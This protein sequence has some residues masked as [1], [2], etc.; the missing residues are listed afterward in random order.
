MDS[1]DAITKAVTRRFK[2]ERKEHDLP[3]GFTWD[4]QKKKYCQGDLRALLR[5]H[6][7]S[8]WEVY[9]RIS[10]PSSPSQKRPR[11]NLPEHPDRNKFGYVFCHRGL[12]DRARG[13]P[14]NSLMAVD[15]GMRNGLFFHELD[16][17]LS[18]RPESTTFGGSIFITHD[19]IASRVS[20]KPRR[21]N[22]Y[23]LSEIKQTP[24]VQRNFNED[25]GTYASS[26][27]NTTQKVPFLG[28]LDPIWFDEVEKAVSDGSDTYIQLDLRGKDFADAL[29]QF[30]GIGQTGPPS[31]NL[32]LKGYNTHFST[33]EKLKAATLNSKLYKNSYTFSRFPSYDSPLRFPFLAI[34]VFYPDPIIDLALKDKHIHLKKVGRYT[35]S[36]E[37]ICDV[38]RTQLLSFHSANEYC[39]IFEIV[40]TGLGLGYN[41]QNGTARNPLDGTL[42][43]DPDVIFQSRV[44]RAM[45]DV[46]LKL[47]ETHP[48][49][50]F[51]SCTRL[52]DVRTSRGVEMTWN[53][54]TG[55]MM[56][57]PDGE[58]G[59]AKRLRAIHGG[60]YPQSDIV[61]ADDPYAEIAARTWIDEHAR[62]DRSK[63]LHMTYNDWI[64]QGEEKAVGLAAAIEKLQGPFLPNQYDEPPDAGLDIVV[65]EGA[66]GGSGHQMQRPQG[67]GAK[68]RNDVENGRNEYRGCC[69]L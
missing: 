65:D 69:V 47:K 5:T 32:I 2:N 14:E 28:D 55:K 56:I 58:R 49:V 35:L 36:Y 61:V 67:H 38:F 50:M 63:L 18:M 8:G 29:C 22:S 10:I 24:L 53:M 16:G 12:Y 66:S 51:S 6:A 45:I 64:K 37:R 59:L 4:E 17:N 19:E 39:F 40:F 30:Y 62:L 21:W 33:Y 60:L 31:R 34:M 41:V 7:Y 11:D 52:C 9:S 27:L 48:R 23:R 25:K 26:Y 3:E 54:K 46:G 42:L 68:Q 20:S 15:N 57:T 44:D 1:E 43:T 13:I